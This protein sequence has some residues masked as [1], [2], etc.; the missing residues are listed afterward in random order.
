LIGIETS[1][2]VVTDLSRS[3]TD[4]TSAAQVRMPGNPAAAAA[5]FPSFDQQR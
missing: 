1:G 2:Y 4:E 3:A 5:G